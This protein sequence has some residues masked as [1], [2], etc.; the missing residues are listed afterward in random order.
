MSL[1][2]ISGEAEEAPEKTGKEQQQRREIRGAES[3]ACP[4][5]ADSCCP[6]TSA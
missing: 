2:G 6:Q 4:P 5:A 3:P 1:W